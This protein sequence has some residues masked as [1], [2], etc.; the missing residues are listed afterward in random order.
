MPAPFFTTNQAEFGRVEAVYVSPRNPPPI[1][2]G[3]AINDVGL[4]GTAARGPVDRRVEITSPGRFAEVFGGRDYGTGGDV[5]SEL[6]RMLLNKFFGRVVCVRVASATATTATVNLTTLIGGTGT[7][8]ARVDAANPGAWGNEARVLVLP[9]SDGVAGKFNLTVEVVTG[10]ATTYPNFDLTGTNDNTLTILGTDDANL[11]TITK[12]AAGTPFLSDP[13]AVPPVLDWRDLAGGGVGTLADT[14]YTA[15]GR[16][17]QLLESYP[18]LSAINC[19]RMT[20]AVRD[21]MKLAAAVTTDRLFLMGHENPATAYTTTDVSTYRSENIFY[22]FNYAYTRDPDTGAELITPA[23]DWMA[24]IIAQTDVDVHP[25]EQDTKRLLAGITRLHNE[26]YNREDYA[27]M[28]ARGLSALEK[29]S[30]G[31]AFVS[32][33]TTTLESGKQEITYK[34]MRNFLEHSI[35]SELRFFVK[36]KNTET[37][38]NAYIA[39]IDAFL[40]NLQQN[41][42][43]V[44]SYVVNV[45]SVNNDLQRAQGIEKILVKV[46]LIGHVLALVL[47]TDISTGTVTALAA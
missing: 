47:E 12:I 11:I 20:A 9:P 43:I 5:K 34:R 26:G 27:Q 17:L 21:R 3:V 10:E 40:H 30:D 42:R 7:V 28:K 36:K 31:F 38:R 19:G 25:G 13:G 14:D 4:V 35:A 24:S 33:V 6:W 16:G 37:T 23:R 15:T 45:K 32:A 46:K 18:G 2:S 39:M 41:E 44:E 1:I 22:G 8:I 29:D